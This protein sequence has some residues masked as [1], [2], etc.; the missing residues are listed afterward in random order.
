MRTPGLFCAAAGH[1]FGIDVPRKGRI[2]STETFRVRDTP[3]SHLR[4]RFVYAILPNHIYG[5]FSC[6]R[7][8]CITS[9]EPFRVRDTPESHLRKHFVY[10]IRLYH[11]YENISYP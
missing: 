5:I 10:A 3:E 1:R 4:N 8:A 9:T 6:T 11:I 7:Y 2:T